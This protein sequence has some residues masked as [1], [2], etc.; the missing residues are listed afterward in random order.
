MAIKLISNYKELKGG[1]IYYRINSF[2]ISPLIIN[3]IFGTPIVSEFNSFLS[4]EYKNNNHKN[5]FNLYIISKIERLILKRSKRIICVSKTLQDQLINKGIST[6]KITVVPNGVDTNKFK[7][8]QNY[9][10]NGKL[11]IGFVGTF[12]PWHGIKLLCESVKELHL[13]NKIDSKVKF[14][15]IGDGL[16]RKYAENELSDLNNVLFFGKISFEK[17]T[18]YL[19][20]CDILL[21]PHNIHPDEENFIGSP[22]KLFEYFAMGKIIVGTNISQLNDILSPS[23]KVDENGAIAYKQHI[24]KE[25][26][27]K[28]FPNK[29]S[30]SSGVLFA[31]QNHSKLRKMALNARKKAVKNFTW[32]SRVFKILEG[33]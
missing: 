17:I 3:F 26:S 4:W 29:N 19:D 2:D 30:L 28:T 7:P 1:Y 27:I 25:N 6:S 8:T 33:F 18:E 9:N 21:S 32:K 5:R 12:G 15:F 14:H 11:T 13:K 10:F 22:T 20:K 23:V 16:L 24:N 31:I